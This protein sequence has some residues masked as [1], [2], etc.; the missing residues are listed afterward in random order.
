MPARRRQIAEAVLPDTRAGMNDHAVADKG[1]NHRRA[2]TDRAIA[3]D[4]D[5][6]SDHRAGCDQCPRADFSAGSDHRQRIDGDARLQPRG[7]MHPRIGRA[8]GRAEQRGRPQR[9]RKQRTRHRD[10]GAVRL[11]HH[12]HGEPFR[13][14]R[15]KARRQQAS[16]GARHGERVEIFRVVEKRD[17]GR[18]RPIKRRNV[19][20]AP[21]ERRAG[22]RLGAGERDDLSDRQLAVGWKE[23]RHRLGPGADREARSEPRTAAELEPLRTV[24]RLFQERIGEIETQRAER[25]I[26]DQA[27]A[28]GHARG[29]AI[30]VLQGAI[31]ANNR[32][33]RYSW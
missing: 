3:P 30:G 6:G 19:A 12:Q 18:P 1:M 17:V 26:P 5:A 20:D 27:G 7:R 29:C 23:I 25:R 21:V 16:A 10:E 33:P 24:V 11:R 2:R 8:A 15:G 14:P 13:R 28:D 31:A 9:R 22:P 32:R 4:G